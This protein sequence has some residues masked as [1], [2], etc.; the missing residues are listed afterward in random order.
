MAYAGYLIKL[1]NYP[2][3]MAW[4]KLD[5]YK[6]IKYV[7]DVDS[8]RDANGI[9]HRT[10]LS[11]TVG[12]VEFETKNMMT[13][14]EFAS[15]MGNIQAQLVSELTNQKAYLASIYI[16]EDDAYITQ[17]VYLGDVQPQIYRGTTSKL[18]YNSTRLSFTGYGTDTLTDI[19]L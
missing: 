5:S 11:A 16:P 8:Y 2:I 13:D 12:K 19:T 6:V 15:L 18:Y 10:A 9:L 17:Y 3:P 4:M 14:K 1:G 7:Q